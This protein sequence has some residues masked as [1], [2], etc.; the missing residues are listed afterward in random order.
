MKNM[1]ASGAKQSY[2]YAAAAVLGLAITTAIFGVTS[3]AAS[4]NNAPPTWSQHHQ[5]MHQ[6]IIDGNYDSWASAMQE[7]VD[8]M[9]QQAN[10]MEGIINQETF[11]KIQE[12]QQLMQSGDTQGAKAIFEEL[13]LKGGYGFVGRGFHKGMHLGCQTNDQ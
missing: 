11:N 6:A 7:K 12:A 13:G 10:E 2:Y 1:T 5:E 4:D 8:L 9:R 3:F